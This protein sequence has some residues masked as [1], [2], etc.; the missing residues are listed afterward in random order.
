MEKLDDGAS[1]LLFRE[2]RTH[3]AWLDRKISDETLRQLYDVAKWV[4]RQLECRPALRFLLVAEGEGETP[5][6]C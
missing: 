2:A 6:H 5:D 3:N 1:D 4:E